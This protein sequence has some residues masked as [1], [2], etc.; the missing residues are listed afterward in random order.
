M[1]AWAGALQRTLIDHIG[2]VNARLGGV[3]ARIGEVAAHIG[4]V[5]TR[6]GGVETRLGGV[7]TRIGGVETRI[8]DLGAYIGGVETTLLRR[9]EASEAAVTAYV[10]RRIEV[11]ESAILARVDREIRRPL[12]EHIDTRTAD[13]MERID[14][15]QARV[16]SHA[17]SL[18]VNLGAS[19][20]AEDKAAEVEEALR[21][22]ER[23]RAQDMRILN[24]M[25]FA[26]QRQIMRLEAQVRDIQ[27]RG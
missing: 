21:R 20:R 17:D 18:Q 16:D 2:G 27:E 23:A 1:P 4:G 26:M 9:I 19:Q 14:R 8:G 12:I 6:L 22:R 5:E 25:V 7:E 10:D 24:D 3:E 15:L 11:A 13:I